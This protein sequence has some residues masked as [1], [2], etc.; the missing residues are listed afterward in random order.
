MEIFLPL[1]VVV[2]IVVGIILYRKG[3]KLPSITLPQFGGSSGGGVLLKYGLIVLG[4][5]IAVI[6]LVVIFNS[7]F[8]LSDAKSP[9]FIKAAIVGIIAGIIARFVQV[10]KKDGG[11]TAFLISIAVAVVVGFLAF[12]YLNGKATLTNSATL[13]KEQSTIR[14]R[15]FGQTFILTPDCSKVLFIKKSDQGKFQDGWEIRN[16]DVNIREGYMDY[17]WAQAEWKF[18]ERRPTTDAQ[19]KLVPTKA[20]KESG[21]PIMTFVITKPGSS[22]STI[23]T[24][25]EE[26]SESK[27]GMGLDFLSQKP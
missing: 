10:K 8:G 3:I 22:E 14:I 19:T 12:G 26:P 2:L 17:H 18:K 21:K 5:L 27:P 4:I 20:F 1:L 11:V 16:V 7:S 6:A 23:P 25:T 15:D 9:L 24:A 13:C